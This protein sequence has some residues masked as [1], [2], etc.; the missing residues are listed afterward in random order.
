MRLNL[1]QQ[2]TATTDNILKSEFLELDIK[3]IANKIA[4]K[5]YEKDVLFYL[6]LSVI[7]ILS[8][9]I[10]RKNRLMVYFIVKWF[11]YCTYVIN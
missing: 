9:V 4:I 1:L 11:E 5:V 7:L 8:L 2:L 6:K 10:Y 3:I